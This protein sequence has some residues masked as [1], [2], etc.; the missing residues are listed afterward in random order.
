MADIVKGKIGNALMSVAPDGIVATAD[1]IY[2][3]TKGK[4]QEQI[5]EDTKQSLAEQANNIGYYECGTA[6]A[7]AAKEITGGGYK[8]PDAAPYGGTIKVKFTHKNSAANPTL[9]INLSDPK[10][11]YYNGAIA[12]STNTW[13]DGD[14]LDLYYDGTN[15][16][17]RSVVEKFST[18]EKVKN[19]GIDSEPRVGSDNL[20]TTGNMVQSLAELTFSPSVLL[21]P[22]SI[23][24]GWKLKSNGICVQDSDYKLVKYSNI[25]EGDVL[26]INLEK[27]SDGVFQFQNNQSVPSN[28]PNNYLIGDTNIYGGIGMVKV[29]TGATFLIV[30][31][32]ISNTSNSIEKLVQVDETPTA[33]SKNLAESGGV[34]T[35]VEQKN[36]QNTTFKSGEK[37]TKVGIEDVLNSI[38]KSNVPNAVQ[39]TVLNDKVIKI[40][41]GECTK[42]IELNDLEIYTNNAYINP[43]DGR[44][45]SASNVYTTKG[46]ELKVGDK[47]RA[48]T[49]GSGIGLIGYRTTDE[50]TTTPALIEYTVLAVANNMTDYIEYTVEADGY[51]SFSGR[52]DSLSVIIG[53]NTNYIGELTELKESIEDTE[54]RVDAVEETVD[55]L[56][57][58]EVISIQITLDDINDDG[59]IPNYYLNSSSLVCSG[60]SNTIITKPIYLNVGDSVTCQTGGTGIVLFGKSPSEN[61]NRSTTG[62]VSIKNANSSSSVTTYSITINEAGWYVFSGRI[63]RTDGTNLVVN[64]TKYSRSKGIYEQ[65][66]DKD[67]NIPAIGLSIGADKV[68][69]AIPASP[70]FD[71]DSQSSGF[72][73][74]T[75]LDDKLDSVPYGQ[76][77]I[78]ITDYHYGSNIKKSAALIDYCRNRLGIKTI[79]HG[80]DVHN[81]YETAERAVQDW[82]GFNRD[83][84]FRIGND[85]KQVLGDHDRNGGTG[86]TPISYE[87]L[88]KLIT[89][90]DSHELTFD[91]LYDE[92]V[93]ELGWSLS[94]MSQYEAFKRMHYFFDDVTI[95]TRFICL[96]TRIIPQGQGLVYEKLGDYDSGVL[97]LQ[98]DFLYSALM[99]T[100][101][102][103][104][105]IVTGHNVVGDKSYSVSVSGSTVS[106]YNV[107]EPVFK[108]YWSNVV[109]QIR[110]LINKSVS[111]E[112]S[113]LDWESSEIETKT[114]DFS[115]APDIGVTF[116]IG[117]D[118]HWDILA[119]SQLLNNTE[120]LSTV[121]TIDLPSGT[122][123]TV[124][125]NGTINK[126]TDILQVVTMTD[127]G[128]RGYRG[129][130]EVPDSNYDDNTDSFNICKPNTAGTID[131]QAFDIITINNKYISFTRIGSGNDRIVYLE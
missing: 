56:I 107:N 121:E 117:G 54:G 99:S 4:S 122:E 34:V 68:K 66:D 35:Y 22:T 45:A 9:S 37:V 106:R 31:Q 74:G 124:A 59:A 108:G 116:C 14:V 90:Y 84:V 113:Y 76:R 102:G 120:T 19:V 86:H 77:F 30:S 118:V 75:Y 24:N 128:D 48:F 18:G 119:K 85:F 114:Y 70:W 127:S 65:L 91:N 57:N 8:L 129:I 46:I 89:G 100:P 98:M 36:T 115:D 104:N 25:Q 82:L 7:T 28:L 39:C 43:T 97:L 93:S 81:E 111:N 32:L 103:Y 20:P 73:Y 27:E 72:D 80:G 51:Y 64:V 96:V 40:T 60:G 109:K 21:E 12:S 61:I 69:D 94:D 42:V 13:E 71:A 53:K 47:I 95:K 52:Q 26:K 1:A 3:E 17:A 58:G 16:N 6:A 33:N 50:S 79:I 110:G 23:V 63:N 112:I 130:V 38:N 10:P 55:E 41:G 126:D 105:I 83:F 62:F 131:S 125:T 2:D 29:P 67:A 78:F 44:L 49:Q 92:Q 123:P 5:N 101:K 11:L 15:F 88:Q 87:V